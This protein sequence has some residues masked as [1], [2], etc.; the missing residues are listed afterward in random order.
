MVTLY[1]TAVAL[2]LS[3]VSVGTNAPPN[4]NA[5]AAV[6]VHAQVATN[7]VTVEVATDVQPAMVVPP[8]L[9][10]TAPATLVVAAR[11]G[12]VPGKVPLAPLKTTV[13][14]ATAA[15]ADPTTKV[16]TMHRAKDPMASIDMILFISFS[17]FW[18]RLFLDGH[19]GYLLDGDGPGERGI[20]GVALTRTSGG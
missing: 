4:T 3:V 7:G 10:V 14:V 17:S 20:E 9:N 16:M 12:V 19:D 18:Y 5:P 1:A 13:D 11:G 15:E 2:P 8:T 6:G